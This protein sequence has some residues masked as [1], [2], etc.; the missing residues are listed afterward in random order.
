MRYKDAAVETKTLWIN[1]AKEWQDQNGELTLVVGAVTWFDDGLPWA[2][3][4][5]DEVVYNA[6][7]G[8]YIRRRGP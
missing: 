3:F 1:E 8:E 5:V 7:V 6:D 2:V 4:S